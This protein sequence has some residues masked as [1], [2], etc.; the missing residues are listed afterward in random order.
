MYKI[1]G[2]AAGSRNTLHLLAEL[3]YTDYLSNLLFCLPDTILQLALPHWS[4]RPQ[5]WGDTVTS[6]ISDGACSIL[7]L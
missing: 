5:G 7:L 4:P 3:V 6:E 1:Q 2:D